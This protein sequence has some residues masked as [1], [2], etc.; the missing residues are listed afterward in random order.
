MKFHVE[1]TYRVQD[2]DK[3][4]TFLHSG[5]LSSDGPAKILGAWIAVQSGT[6]YAMI[7][8]DDSTAIYLLCSEWAKYGQINVTPVIDA[9]SI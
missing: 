1:L 9:S 5:G 7:E 3:L 2:R 6:G 4:L 8:T